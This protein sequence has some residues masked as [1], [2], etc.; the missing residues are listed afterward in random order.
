MNSF[1][2]GL[3]QTLSLEVSTKPGQVLLPTAYCLLPTAYCLLGV[4]PFWWTPVG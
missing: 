2:K 1:H 4:D 3:S